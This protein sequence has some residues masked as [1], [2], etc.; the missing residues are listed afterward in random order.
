MTTL[1]V[2][3]AWAQQLFVFIPARQSQK[4]AKTRLSWGPSRR[5]LFGFGPWVTMVVIVC[6]FVSSRNDFQ[7]GASLSFRIQE[8]PGHGPYSWG[9]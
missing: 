4:I 5:M 6:Q 8:G 2:A 3:R 9:L 1:T 7:L